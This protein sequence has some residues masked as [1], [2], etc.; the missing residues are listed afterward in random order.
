MFNKT[1]NYSNT[2]KEENLNFPLSNDFQIKIPIEIQN[3]I[4][5]R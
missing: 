4:N 1:K 5:N 2:K 3:Q